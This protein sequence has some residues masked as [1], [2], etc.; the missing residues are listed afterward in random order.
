MPYADAPRRAVRPR[1]ERRDIPA[2]IGVRAAHAETP[3]QRDYPV[4]RV[5]LADPA[6]IDALAA[7]ASFAV[8]PKRDRR[9][10]RRQ[11]TA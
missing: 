9:R 1:A 3:Q 5:A 2:E 4:R 6:E 11:P 10:S 8:R 7:F